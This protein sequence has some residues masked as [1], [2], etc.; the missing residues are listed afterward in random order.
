[1]NGLLKCAAAGTVV[2]ACLGCGLKDYEQRMDFQA[3]RLA[4]FD[5]LEKLLDA[6]LAMPAPGEGQRP[7][8][9][10]DVYLRPPRGV[11]RV[12][13]SSLAVRIGMNGLVLYRYALQQDK[14]GGDPDRPEKIEKPD[15]NV[16]VA[17]SKVAPD[18]STLDVLT[19]ADFRRLVRKA[20]AEYFAG[21]H[22]RTP[23]FT[24]I[25]LPRWT[26]NDDDAT[27]LQF[28]Q[29]ELAEST[30]VSFHLFFRTAS[31]VQ[32]A[33]VFSMPQSASADN[34]F[35]QARDASLKTMDIDN[36]EQKRADYAK[37]HRFRKTW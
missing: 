6:P 8:W 14:S 25:E 4:A 5:N 13:K 34:K 7:A 20:I 1:M 18:R 27:K 19:T 11:D 10:S 30:G 33:V 24:E 2:F 21:A 9:P 17:V 32:A 22:G 12:C 31:D 36:A 3:Q 26:V 16:F 37:T 15:W 28:D 29:L 35:R 23:E